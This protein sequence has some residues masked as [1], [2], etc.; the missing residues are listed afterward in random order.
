MS[1]RITAGET[2][3]LP[4]RV[5]RVS[6]WGTSSATSS[7]W[8]RS[9]GTSTV[10]GNRVSS[11]VRSPSRSPRCLPVVPPPSARRRR[12]TRGSGSST[13]TSTDIASGGSVS[14]WVSSSVPPP[15]ASS[16]ITSAT[17]RGP[18]SAASSTR[19]CA[20]GVRLWW[21]ARASVVFPVPGS[22][23]STSHSRRAEGPVDGLA[24]LR[25]Q[26][27][28][29]HGGRQRGR[30]QRGA[31]AARGH[32][33]DHLHQGDAARAAA[34][35]EARLALDAGGQP[36]GQVHQQLLAAPGGQ[37]L[38][39]L[40]EQRPLVGGGEQVARPVVEHQQVV[41]DGQHG[42]AVAPAGGQV[43]VQQRVLAAP[44]VLQQHRLDAPAQR[45]RGGGHHGA[46]VAAPA[47]EVDDAEHLVRDRVPHRHPGT[48]EL[49]QVLHVVLV[50]ED[51][52]RAAALQRGADA[53]G[54]DVLLGVAEAGGEPDPV[55][56]LLQALVAGVAGEDDAVGVAEDDA[57]GLAGELLRGLRQH[58]S[59]GAQQGGLAVQVGLERDVEVVDRD[60][61]EPGPGPRRQDRLPHDVRRRGA[62]GEERDA[63]QRQPGRP[64]VFRGQD[65]LR[66][67]VPS[68]FASAK[69]TSSELQRS[70][71][72]RARRRPP[73]PST[74]G[75]GSNATSLI[76]RPLPPAAEGCDPSHE[77][78]PVPA[79]GAAPDQLSE[80][81]TPATV[82]DHGHPPP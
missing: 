78:T 80:S 13:S 42:V 55:Q 63:G 20:A 10:R 15:V 59:R 54:A 57:D 17:Q 31:R 36:A 39:D 4:P 30:R 60:V 69:P 24:A 18:Y 5:S 23:S 33:A 7:T 32:L 44:G 76:L 1:T 45:R 11:V 70:V 26:R 34:L 12:S 41:A 22:P 79:T 14:T 16:S 47:R 71:V 77:A 25:P 8:W 81:T 28:G 51:P 49:L 72:E 73:S 2:E 66:G 37:R 46:G 82:V 74:I 64:G 38:G 9:G 65:R 61:P 75:G 67:A 3:R 6:R 40:R 27:P 35:G 21:T 19:R 58:R 52:R 29:A 50:A 68:C 56:A 43:V 62:L 53:V 48:G